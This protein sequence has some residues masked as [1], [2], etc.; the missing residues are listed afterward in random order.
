[1]EEAGPDKEGTEAKPPGPADPLDA[2]W[3]MAVIKPLESATEAINRDPPGLQDTL[4]V[5]QQVKSTV[6]GFTSTVATQGGNPER[7]SI[8]LNELL[9]AE[10]GLQANLGVPMDLGKLQEE[11][12][13]IAE[14]SA[15]EVKAVLH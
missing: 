15:P 5:V 14:T 12:K 7:L 2:M 10:R 8:L 3:E 13:G 1:E 11:V 6:E 9:A 4:A